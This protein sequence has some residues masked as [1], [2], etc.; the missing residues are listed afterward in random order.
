MKIIWRL[1]IPLLV[2][3]LCL[4]ASLIVR[5]FLLANQHRDGPTIGSADLTPEAW[6]IPSRNV[7]PKLV[8]NTLIGTGLYSTLPAA[9]NG[10]ETFPGADVPFGMVQWSPDTVD[11]TYSGYKYGDK[12][13]RGFSLTHLSGAG[14]SQFGDLPFMPYTGS[15]SGDPTQYSSTFSHANELGY[16]GYYRVKLD[17]GITTE[18]TVTPHSG[19]MRLTYPVGAPAGLLVKAGGSLNPV[20]D[21]EVTVSNN[22]NTVLGAEATKENNV[23]SGWV[24]SGDFCLTNSN[25]YRVYFWAQFSQPF[26]LS[27]TWR[28]GALLDNQH[29][30][31]GPDSGVFVTFN[32]N[33]HN[34]I[35]V[36]V[37]L[38]YVSVANAEANVNAEDPT[39]N[40][41]A[42][43]EQATRLWE[44]RL[45][46]I[47]IN[48]GT[49]L[50]RAT[51][52][53]AL[54]HA[55][56][57]PS[58]FSDV[59]G[60]YIGFD[61]KVHSVAPGHA[62]YAN[63]SGWDI[64]RSEAQ[65]L[66]LLAPEQASDMAQSLVNDYEQGGGLPKWP[67]ANGET[68]AQ[69]GDPAAAI[70]ADIYAF[71]GTTFDVR[72]ALNAMIQQAT[73]PN[74]ERP[75]LK[76]MQALGY[77]PVD[78]SYICCHFYGPAATSLEYD[79][80]D[81]AVSALASSLGDD[82]D[83]TK[84]SQ[85]AQGWTNLFNDAT[86]YMAPRYLNGSFYAAATP[87]SEP[88][89]VEGNSA[90]Y[91]WMVPFN[92]SALFAK[93]GGN[94]R[95][96][97]RLDTFFTHLDVGPD[98]PYAFLGN[99]PTLETPWEYDYAGAPY[100]TQQ[101]VREAINQLYSPNPNGLPGNDDLGEMS[102][103]YIF[104]ALGM[105]PETPGTAVL[106][107]AS[108][109]FPQIVLHRPSGQTIVINAPNA[110]AGAPYVQRLLVDGQP[111]THPWLPP[112]FVA[113]GGT[114]TYTLSNMPDP[115]WGS[116]A[117]D[118]PPSYGG[119]ASA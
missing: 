51:F 63:F 6:G 39:G 68:Y 47:Q 87:S 75:G 96:V 24:S 108:P 15:L 72:T 62:Q 114:L 82:K 73:Q 79:T 65:L 8:V 36:R 91:T 66:A 27:G 31:T 50:Q 2:L 9:Y 22:N 113:H 103:W 77:E 34:V 53:T 32:T 26:L 115:A 94:A 95:V 89:W 86:G 105:Y 30:T 76:Y 25:A 52:Y 4:L 29:Q 118:A 100:K 88:G 42:V 56:L 43:H 117:S 90:Q 49:A 84:F 71:G 57:F 48:G 112:S 81:F 98:K 69:V 5:P 110:S 61:S 85:K 3:G 83:A 78:G 20:T 38:S 28:D 102:S 13:I 10:G 97:Q 14:C 116:A 101:I 54:Y 70:I 21:V 33:L 41:D 40:F 107:L 58:I 45:N 80:A 64:Y 23:I 11:R 18:L 55:L 46:E 37:G 104:S 59:N 16:A 60:Q 1:K 19:V 119:Q 92:L 17:N 93:M 74:Q 44:Q 106:A 35:S 109:L 99:E 67:I 7:D 111:S 12:R